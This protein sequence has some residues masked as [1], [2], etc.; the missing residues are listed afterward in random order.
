VSHCQRTY[1]GSAVA[2]C[3]HLHLTQRASGDLISASLRLDFRLLIDDAS[4]M[5][6]RGDR[7]SLRKNRCSNQYFS[8]DVLTS[9]A[10]AFKRADT[11]T[12]VAVKVTRCT[13][14]LLI[15]T[16][17][18]ASAMAEETVRLALIET[19]SG[20]AATNGIWSANHVRWAVDRVNAAGG[21]LG[22]KRIALVE[23]DNKGSPQEAVLAL[24][25]V[26]DRK[27]RYLA[28]AVGS[29]ISLALSDAIA[30]H[31]KR[32]PETSV[33]FLNYGG[34]STE[35]TNEKCS[36]WHF[37]FEANADMK[38]EA[39]MRQVASNKSVGKVYLINQDYAYGQ[40]V[41]S[42][43]RQ[44]LAQRL[45]N[46]AIVGDDLVP[47]QKTKDFAPYVAKI[48]AAGADTVLT[49]NWG[50]D[51][52]LLVRAARD[53]GLATHF[54]TLHAHHVGTPTAIGAP[55]IGHVVNLS[56]WSNNAEDSTLESYYLGYKRYYKQEWN[57]L[58]MKNAVEMWVKAI[59]QA[60]SLDPLAVGKALEGMRYDAG[61][62]TMWMRGEDHQLMLPQYA[63]Q[64][65]QAGATREARRRRHRLWV[66]DRS[67][68]RGR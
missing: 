5:R 28:G 1:L 20:P 58:P 34:L 14:F 51:L 56:S 38:V 55:G 45:S 57:M 43:M 26:I 44:F 17:C 27:I 60:R 33:L 4:H 3:I 21:I 37:R 65:R 31:N 8:F 54:Y 35:L 24:N 62:G 42:R 23:F 29:H 11:Y 32:S 47:L 7:L 9:E 36:F 15:T 12:E 25:E 46:V 59:E 39:L 53:S 66:S 64:L 13:L 19:L 16:M 2:A 63:S 18:C 49:S 22:D 61:T 30:K 52:I 40:A 6:T 10:V 41:R 50:P 67:A 68:L 48:K